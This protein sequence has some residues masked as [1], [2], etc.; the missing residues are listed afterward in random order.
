MDCVMKEANISDDNRRPKL[1]PTLRNII[2]L[3]ITTLL[4]LPLSAACLPVFLMGLLV[5]EQ[6]PTIPIWSR[7]CKYFTAVF[8]EGKSEDN[9]PFT[10]RVITFMLLFNIAVKVPVNGVCW[11]LDELLY[12]DY[13][14]VNIKEPV[15]FLTAPRSGSTQLCQYLEDDKESFIIPTVGEALFPYIWFWKLFIPMLAR[16]GIN[17]QKFDFSY[18]YG[19]GTEAIKRHEVGFSKAA[20]WGSLIGTWHIKL[21][22]WCLGSSFFKWGYSYAKLEEPIDEE[23]YSSSILLFT[24]HVMR[25]VIYLRGSPKQRVLLKGHFLLSAESLKQQ[26]PKA[27]F[28]AVVRQ[29]PDRLLSHINLLRAI[30]VDGPHCKKCGVHSTPTSCHTI[31]CVSHHQNFGVLCTP[32]CGVT[33][34]WCAQAMHTNC[35]KML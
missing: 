17:Q 14:K 25:K 28:F 3:C 18:I 20:T 26:Y 27:K 7:M 11:F 12:P 22:S 9:V 35:H 32:S 33:G 1:L 29:P 4:W 30:S 6:P 16:L 10:N 15:F 5:W 23:F 8:T 34:F 31:G 13:H 19:F 2:F 21:F 24:N